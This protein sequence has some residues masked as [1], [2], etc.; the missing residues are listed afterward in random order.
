MR[1]V[2]SGLAFVHSEQGDREAARA[3][4]ERLATE[5]FADI[6]SELAWTAVMS[7]LTEV[8]CFLGDLPRARLLYGETLFAALNIA[9]GPVPHTCCG[10]IAHFLGMLAAALGDK[11]QA[12][13]HF[14]SALNMETKMRMPAMRA[15]TQYEYGRM[16]SRSD[17]PDATQVSR[18]EPKASEDHERGAGLLAAAL[19]AAASLGMEALEGQVNALLAELAQQTASAADA[20]TG[21]APD[22]SRNLFRREGEYWTIAYEG[23][24]FR[25]RDTKGLA[26]L[27][28]LL[29]APTREFFALDLVRLGEEHVGGDAR[30]REDAAALERARQSITIAIRVAQRKISASDPALGRHLASTIHTGKLCVYTPGPGTAAW[31]V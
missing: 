26:Y 4:F 24:T 15:R 3:E 17:R 7:N 14:E 6:P 25:S 5:D 1:G 22:S 31:S 10:P 16:L 19:E 13:E 21:T 12:A 20:R 29:R 11:K 23:R 9:L 2:T 8:C 18:S 28:E 27:A 30:L